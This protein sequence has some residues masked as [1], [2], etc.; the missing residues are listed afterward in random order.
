MESNKPV[1]E[2][3]DDVVNTT[4]NEPNLVKTPPVTD[5]LDNYVKEDAPSTPT[6]ENKDVVAIINHNVT[7]KFKPYEIV[8]TEINTTVSLP[9]NDVGELN[10]I[11]EKNERMADLIQ[12]EV[13]PN[14]KYEAV[15]YNMLDH[16]MMGNVFTKSL[17]N[18]K[19][20]WQQSVEVDGVTWK[21]AKPQFKKPGAGASINASQFEIEL[22]TQYGT[23][24]YFTVP[25]VHSGIWLSLKPPTNIEFA[26]FD[27][28]IKLEKNEFGKRT[29]GMVYSNTKAFIV[30]HLIKFIEDHVSECNVVDW[31][32]VGLASL[33]KTTDLLVL[34]AAMGYCMYPTGFEYVSPCTADNNCTHIHHAKL[35]MANCI[36]FDRNSLSTEQKEFMSKRNVQHTVDEVRAY[37]KAVESKNNNFSPDDKIEIF[38]QVPTIEQHI[39]SGY[40]WFDEIEKAVVESFGANLDRDQTDSYIARHI[41]LSLLR[42]YGH[43]FKTIRFKESGAYIDNTSDVNRVLD[44]L[45]NIEGMLDNI[46]EE[47]GAF[48]EN[49]TKALVAIPRF[50]CPACGGE[51]TDEIE[52]HP[53]LIPI[54]T[55]NLFFTLGNQKILFGSP[56]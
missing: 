9:N 54:D 51:Q 49:Q 6:E 36:W 41:G 15:V 4:T 38:L 14:T 22:D 45:S 53:Y 37:Q 28:K 39:E 7:M 56:N 3:K 33:V 30:N 35:K 47:V 46:V 32:T 20:D 27:E 43:F 17:E 52:K 21:V 13:A 31:K 26:T 2:V 44:K 42:Q 11:G 29:L 24:G 25:L 5:E 16:L 10:K 50:N 34:A 48:I 12:Q 8:D 1:N 23:G 18:D 19:S 55:I 40:N